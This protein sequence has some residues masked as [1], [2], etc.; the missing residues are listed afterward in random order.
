MHDV[1]YVMHTTWNY[2]DTGRGM[3]VDVSIIL[4]RVRFCGTPRLLHSKAIHIAPWQVLIDFHSYII[5]IRRPWIS[6]PESQFSC[7]KGKK[8]YIN[9]WRYIFFIFLGFW[10][11]LARPTN[12]GNVTL[13]FVHIVV[14]IAAFVECAFFPTR[15]GRHPNCSETS[16]CSY[17]YVTHS[18]FLR[19]QFGTEINV[20]VDIHIC[21]TRRLNKCLIQQA[22]I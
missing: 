12:L 8:N 5:N 22:D 1:L 16:T 21:Q 15:Q 17:K 4:L 11:G 10:E 13:T 7:N 20:M 6:T 2:S 19:R 9:K 14:D 3:F 18:Y